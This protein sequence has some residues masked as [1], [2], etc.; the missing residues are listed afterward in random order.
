MRESPLIYDAVNPAEWSSQV[1]TIFPVI[2]D[3]ADNFMAHVIKDLNT[4]EH[5]SWL[6]HERKE[7]R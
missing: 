7:S 1:T 2:F 3:N 5:Q 6:K 4:Q